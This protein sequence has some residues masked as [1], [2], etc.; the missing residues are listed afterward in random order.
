VALHHKSIE[1]FLDGPEH[2]FESLRDGLPAVRMLREGYDDARIV[3]SAQQLPMPLFDPV[4]IE[5]LLDAP[6]HPAAIAKRAM[7]TI[8]RHLRTPAPQTRDRP[9]INVPAR[10]A[11]WFV[12]GM[13]DS[14]TVSKADG[15]GVA[16]RRRDPQ[17][18]RALLARTVALYRRLV[19]EWDVTAKRYRAA[20]PELT[21]VDS[22]EQMF[23]GGESPR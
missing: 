15:S 16:F 2:L 13:V 6:V 5:R 11:R 9:Q 4:R 20:V 19:V 7:S 23:K 14:A 3:P 10:N 18:F 21:S 1:D 12:L 8:F 17:Q 22:W